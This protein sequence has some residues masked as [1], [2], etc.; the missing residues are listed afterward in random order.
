MPDKAITAASYTLF[1]GDQDADRSIKNQRGGR[2]ILIKQSWGIDC[3]VISCFSVVDVEYLT[4]KCCSFF[5]TKEV[6]CLIIWV[7]GTVV[8]KAIVYS[9]DNDVTLNID[10]RGRS[11]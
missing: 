11:L 7:D 6:Q 2:A 10:K 9:D 3:K 8:N 5:F 1:R 4:L